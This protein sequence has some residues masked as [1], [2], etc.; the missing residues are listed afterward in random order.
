MK[1][2]RTRLEL[3]LFQLR[4]ALKN[5]QF[6]FILEPKAKYQ[7][8][9]NIQLESYFEEIHFYAYVSA[10]QIPDLA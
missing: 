6:L 1:S 10:H 3:K 8:F 2:K 7:I 5:Y 4:G 9:I